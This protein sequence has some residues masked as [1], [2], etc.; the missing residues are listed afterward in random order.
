MSAGNGR[1][2]ISLGGGSAVAQ[3]NQVQGNFIGTDVTGTQ[4][5]GNGG[6]GV[7]AT[8]AT[9]NT[10]G[11][12][13]F[14]AGTPPANLI[15]GNAGSGVGAATGVTGLAIKGNSIHSNGGLGIDLN[16]DGPTV[17]DISEA[18]AD[19]GPNLLQNYPILT[20]FF[21]NPGTSVQFNARFKS[22]PNTTYHIEFF[23]NDASDPTGFGE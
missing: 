13:I 23:S 7:F 1:H 22:R 12:T 3:N 15:A 14:S 2:G 16:R 4:L 19:T 18:D 11:G 10:I 8:S 21:S 9:N 20:V 17:N 6:D 5:R